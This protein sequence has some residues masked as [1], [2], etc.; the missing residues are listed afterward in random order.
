MVLQRLRE[1]GLT[2][3]PK[4]CQFA[5]EKCVY[6][7]HVVG[8]GMVHPEDMKVEAVLNTKPPQTKKQTE[9]T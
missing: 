9:P 1:A 5:R 8:G 4:K 3:K 6:L 2:A 7:G